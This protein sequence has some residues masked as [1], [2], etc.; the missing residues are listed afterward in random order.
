MVVEHRSA[1]SNLYV[2]VLQSAG[3]RQG[4]SGMTLSSAKD[5]LLRAI[6]GPFG[7]PNGGPCECAR[8]LPPAVCDRPRAI[9]TAKQPPS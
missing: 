2:P 7:R 4:P 8:I 3:D 1:T 9:G 5:L 6:L